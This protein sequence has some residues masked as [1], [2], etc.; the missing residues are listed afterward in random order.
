MESHLI[1]FVAKAFGVA[2]GKV[3]I[4]SGELSREKRLCITEPARI[5]E[6]LDIQRPD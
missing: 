2:K 4:V 3:K 1:R 6:T 5:P